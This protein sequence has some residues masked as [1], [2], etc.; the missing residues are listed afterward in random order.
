MRAWMMDAT[1]T[2]AVFDYA[3]H[4]AGQ[5]DEITRAWTSVTYTVSPTAVVTHTDGSRAAVAD[6]S[7][8]SG[9]VN[10]PEGYGTRLPN[11]AYPNPQALV[12]PFSR[13]NLLGNNIVIGNRND[14]TLTREFS[15]K[16][17]LFALF[18]VTLT[19]AECTDLFFRGETTLMSLG[20]ELPVIPPSCVSLKSCEELTR[21]AGRGSWP[22]GRGD[23][24]VCA[25]SDAGIDG[26]CAQD[27]WLE[28]QATCYEVGARLC[29]IEEIG[30]G[31]TQ[32][33][34]CSHDNRQVWSSSL[35]NAADGVGRQTA[36]GRDGSQAQCQRDLS[37]SAAIRCC[38]DI[39]QIRL[40][41]SPCDLFASEESDCTSV[42]SCDQLAERDGNSWPTQ[43]GNA[44]VC[45]ES[46]AGLGEGFARQCFD[47]QPWS[48]AHNICVGAGARLCTVEELHA[49]E[50][51]GTGCSLDLEMVWSINDI[52]CNSHEHVMVPG[53]TQCDGCDPYATPR[54]ALDESDGAVRCCADA[55]VGTP[56]ELEPVENL[57]Q[58]PGV[59]VTLGNTVETDT[60][61]L[62]PPGDPRCAPQGC[63]FR[64]GSAPTIVDMSHAPDEW[65]SSPFGD[66]PDCSTRLYV[67]VDLGQSYP[68]DGVT[69]WHYHG[70]DRSYCGQKVALSATGQ[71]MGEEIVV[72]ET[73]QLYGDKETERGKAI[74]FDRI[75]ARYV[76]HWSSRSD[77]NTG[78]HF[79]EIDVYGSPVPAHPLDLCPA[80][81]N[82]VEP[83]GGTA[84]AGQQCV[85][86]FTYEGRVYNACTDVNYEGTPWCSVDTEYA[87]NWG[88][89]ECTGNFHAG[90]CGIDTGLVTTTGGTASEGS[91]CVFPFEYEGVSYNSCT[92]A[93][94]T[95]AGCSHWCSTT[96][97]YSD[98]WGNCVCSPTD[99]GPAGR[100]ACANLPDGAV[101]ETDTGVSGTCH[102]LVCE[103]ISWT[104]RDNQD[105]SKFVPETAHGPL[106]TLAD[107]EAACRAQRNCGGVADANCDG[108]TG[109]DTFR[110]CLG[111][112]TRSDEATCMWP[113]PPQGGGH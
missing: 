110:L 93:G 44:A 100:A 57:D 67:T 87:G 72:Y 5:F 51:K 101:C 73:G 31:E 112:R 11:A 61:L 30:A 50:T 21:V 95:G 43:N 37:V 15:G 53:A 9:F 62:V 17:A 46:D 29:T 25:E 1:Q 18:D 16:I 106:M 23:P 80:G 35:C 2:M 40:T 105:C 48:R 65:T 90:M 76:R 98:Q 22:T 49:D 58:L 83:L 74:V 32:G 13:F 113:A 38:A 63:G 81:A 60:D 70:D 36:L 12:S 3:L 97:V 27:G 82:L 4:E 68:V 99:L 64:G 94:C 108:A 52:G 85:F 96:D 7:F 69:I 47:A 55:V 56:C 24:D 33:T 104:R 41:K 66:S 10:D 45:G 109:T 102:A 77:R 84:T 6:Y 8:V 103:S 79:M 28:A 20:P 59:T 39:E 78:I 34:G 86:P 75:V 111:A 26:G 19:D 88:V 71:F 91:A 54:C 92:H 42:L 14:A 107:A 89:C